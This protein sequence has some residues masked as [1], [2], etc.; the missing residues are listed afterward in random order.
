MKHL[1][2]YFRLSV[3]CS[4]SK[5]HIMSFICEKVNPVKIPNFKDTSDSLMCLAKIVFFYLELH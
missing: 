4:K 3:F 5:R 2:T 1:N